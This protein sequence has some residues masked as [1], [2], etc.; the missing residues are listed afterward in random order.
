MVGCP[1]GAMASL[2]T[3][4][5][6]AACILGGQGT[7]RIH[8]I[9]IPSMDIH[10]VTDHAI[11]PLGIMGAVITGDGIHSATTM[12]ATDTIWRQQ[13][14]TNRASLTGRAFRSQETDRVSSLL[15]ARATA[16]AVNGCRDRQRAQP[17]IG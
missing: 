6:M 11:T 10:T 8:S 4:R 16:A 3:H 14:N 1:G 17:A 9:D 15:L 5:T 2:D 13:R 12:G 7:I